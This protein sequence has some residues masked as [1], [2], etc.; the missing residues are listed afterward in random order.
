M[1]SL[2]KA[3]VPERETLSLFD[4]RF[5]IDKTVCSEN[6]ATLEKLKRPLPDDDD[7]RS[8]GS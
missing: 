5:S 8:L 4:D 6:D 2:T 3:N 7:L 1:D